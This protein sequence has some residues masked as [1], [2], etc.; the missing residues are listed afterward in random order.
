MKISNEDGLAHPILLLTIVLVVSGV[1]FAGYRVYTSNNNKDQLNNSQ[2]RAPEKEMLPAS[3]ENVL[4]FEK[5][6]EIATQSTDAVITALELEQKDNALV[7]KIVLSDGTVKTLNAY[8]GEIVADASHEEKHVEDG[9]DDALPANFNINISFEKAREVAQAKFPES[10]ISK[11]HIDVEEGVLV[12][13]V[14]FADKARVD[15][16]ADN[17]EVVRTKSPKVRQE[18]KKNN[19]IKESSGDSATARNSSSNKSTYK[20]TKSESSNNSE[21][22]SSSSGSSSYSE[23]GNSGSGSSNNEMRVEGILV[24]SHGAYKVS[25]N[26]KT[27]TIQS[28]QNLAGLVGKKVRVEG[29]LLSSNVISAEKVD[30]R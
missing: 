4:P 9:E 3:L 25:E 19:R 7:Y 22:G 10:K 23:N 15:V 21:S 1:S 12:I 29:A 8:T 24:S 5:I 11:L 17:G 6:K 13:S 30:E 28:S 2:E 14:R 18:V 16:N 27:Y 20:A 26:G